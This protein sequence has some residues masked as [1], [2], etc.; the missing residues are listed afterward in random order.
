MTK[1]L[2]YVGQVFE[3][4]VMRDLL[5]Y[6]QFN[7]ASISYYR[8]NSGLEVDAIL[9]AADSSW[10]AIEIKLGLRMLDEA[11]ANLL[12][13]RDKVNTGRMGEPKALV[14]ITSSGYAFTR[15][16]G[17]HVIPIDRLGP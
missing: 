3:N 11:A 4:L 17:V 2:S 5:V 13:F 14:I 12:K 1:D 7:N 6:A 9:E 15:P 10:I 16:D 8:D